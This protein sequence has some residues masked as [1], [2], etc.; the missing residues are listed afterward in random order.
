MCVPRQLNHLALID[1][2][3]IYIFGDLWEIMEHCEQGTEVHL[4][5]WEHW[6]FSAVSKLYLSPLILVFYYFNV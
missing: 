1:T 3:G 4:K 2:I 5:T 6:M